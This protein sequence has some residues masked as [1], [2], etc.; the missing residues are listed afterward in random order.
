MR[1]LET[2]FRNAKALQSLQRRLL[3]FV[4][5]GLLVAIFSFYAQS[6]KAAE[7]QNG[8]QI[9]FALKMAGDANRMRT[10]IRFDGEPDPNWFLLRNPHRLIIDFPRLR[11]GFAPESLEPR[12]MI[13]NVRYGLLNDQRSRM[14]LS[15]SGAFEVENFRIE[16]NENSPGYRIIVDLISVPEARFAQLLA[17]QMQT[18]GATAAN[19]SD[20]LGSREKSDASPFTVVI[21]PG[22]G[23]I[24]G[25]AR[26]V[27]GS[28]EKEITLEFAKELKKY[29][30]EFEKIRVFLTRED[31]IF[32]KLD[33]RVRIARQY[34]A[35]LFLS[36][37]ADKVRQHDVR[38]A[39]VY[40]LSEKASDAVASALAESENR[41]DA[42]AGME[43]EDDSREVTDI[44]LDLVRRETQTFS[45]RL[46]RSI[47]NALSESVEMINNPHR[48]AGF[49][50]L[51]AHDV[52]SVLVELGYLSNDR[53]EALMHDLS[54]RTKV[55][56]SLAAALGDYREQIATAGKP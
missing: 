14:I 44:L 6:L 17:D 32:L 48:A 53:D 24:D 30:E 22:H 43:I 55:V 13:A 46:A 4:F 47:V 7:Q 21:D 39:T 36:I 38:G 31:D 20:R 8:E 1:P 45:V 18:T 3:L 19:K 9:A 51:R 52:P 11:F 33:E 12:G 56:Q 26:G 10:V 54:W 35:D 23:G 25:G 28:P 2:D 42:I 29:L 34:E 15:M 41:A 16:E 5:A 40:T 49:R 37:H 27:K 50:V